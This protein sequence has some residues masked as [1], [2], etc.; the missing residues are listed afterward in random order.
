M[1]GDAA[2]YITFLTSYFWQQGVTS[3]NVPVTSIQIKVPSPHRRP[4]NT[5][6]LKAILFNEYTTVHFNK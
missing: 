5:T 4:L 1:R 3:L 2:L 6:Y